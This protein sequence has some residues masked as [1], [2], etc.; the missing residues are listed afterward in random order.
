MWILPS[1]LRESFHSAQGCEDLNEPLRPKALKDRKGIDGQQ[2]QDNHNMNGRNQE[3]KK[4]VLS[5][6]WVAMLMNTTL[7]KTFFAYSET[8]WWKARQNSRGGL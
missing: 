3:S 1:Q 4:K 5:P 8:R 2:D 6:A 7:E